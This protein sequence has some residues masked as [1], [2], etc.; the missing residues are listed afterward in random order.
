MKIFFTVFLLC[1]SMLSSAASLNKIVVFGDSLSDTG[2][3]YEYMKH[4]LPLSPPYFQ[5]RFCNGP[6]WVELLAEF[7]YPGN[8]KAHLLNYAFGGAGVSEE[9]D[10]DDEDDDAL[11]TLRREVDSYLLAH[12][13]K[14]DENNL[15]VIWMGSNNYLAVPDD[16]DQAVEETLLGIRHSLERLADK[17]AKHI[18]VVNLPDLGKTPAARDFDAVDS[19]TYASSE[20][21]TKLNGMV[22][23]LNVKYAGVQWL[24]FDVNSLL[25]EMLEHPVRYG[26]TNIT[27]TCYEEMI[28]HPSSQ[29]I[30]KMASMVKPRES[31]DACSGYLFFD[32]VHPTEPAHQLMAERVKTLMIEAGIEF[33]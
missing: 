4:Q 28:G 18:M 11:F 27:D 9:Q 21:N 26:L 5:G 7:Y 13:D 15:Y 29:S 33:R 1:F 10:E 22:L 23:D 30:L 2:N 25:G 6:L 3:L 20:H 19:L 16:T 17:G 12:Q 8:S 24:L 14:A 31:V 32:P